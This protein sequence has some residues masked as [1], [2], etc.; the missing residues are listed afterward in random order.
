MI[1][2]LAFVELAMPLLENRPR[3][4]VGF[5]CI[6]LVSQ[7]SSGNANIASR[8]EYTPCYMRHCWMQ[9]LICARAPDFD[10]VR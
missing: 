5:T 2:D 4:G 10:Y 9:A 3:L 1:R 7:L 8:S 6:G